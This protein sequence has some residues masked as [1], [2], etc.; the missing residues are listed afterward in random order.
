MAHPRTPLR[1][2]TPRMS[3][4]PAHF[5]SRSTRR[6]RR[7][8]ANLCSPSND[9]FIPN[10]ARMDAGSSLVK[11]QLKGDAEPVTPQQKYYKRQLRKALFGSDEM[12]PRMLSIGN[13]DRRSRSSSLPRTEDPCQQDILRASISTIPAVRKVPPRTISTIHNFMLQAPQLLQDDLLS[14]VSSGPMLAVALNDSVY[15]SKDG[16][17]KKIRNDSREYITSV[18]WSGNDSLLAFGSNAQVEVWDPVRGLKAAELVNHSGYVTALDWNG[19]FDLMAASDTGVQRYDLRIAFPEVGTYDC[20]GQNCISSLKWTQ[21][22]MLAV[23]GGNS[24]SLWD[25]RYATKPLLMLDHET[26]KSVDFCPAQSNVLAS[27]GADGIKLWNVHTGHIRASISTDDTVVTSV[28]WSPYRRELMAGYGEKLGVWSVKKNITQLAEWD[29]YCG[30][31]LSLERGYQNGE[32]ISLHDSELLVGW[33]AFG[34][35]PKP[36]DL[37]G[38]LTRSGLLEM[39]VIR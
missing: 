37:C 22:N 23:S 32:V 16:K 34:A 15:L 5:S 11:T 3:P 7:A 30:R 9:R 19:D 21:D 2:Q 8:A 12:E 18:K 38:N 28:V 33:E 35:A 17:V 39:P 26:V 14:L 25:A 27:G 10:R 36:T 6:S 20:P 13:G 31:V 4:S 29:A 1:V 24:I